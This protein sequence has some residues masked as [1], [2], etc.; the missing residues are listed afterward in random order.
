M[1]FWRLYRECFSDCAVG[2]L[3]FY[4]AAGH[5]WRA[6][7]AWLGHDPE[8]AEICFERWR[9]LL[10]HGKHTQVLMEL[11]RLVNRVTLNAESMKVLAQVQADFQNHCQHVAY[12]AFEQEQLPLGSGLV[13]SACKWLIQQRF[14]W[15][16]MGWSSTGF[17]H[18]LY[19]RLAWV[20][21]RGRYPFPLSPN[22]N[23]QPLDAPRD[24]TLLVRPVVLGLK[25]NTRNGENFHCHSL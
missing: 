14:K 25:K 10:R 9:H 23:P 20:N 15:V 7:T 22:V 19:L 1:G 2:I 17:E 5:L 6:A 11:T 24:E 12:S 4:H 21:Q 8:A 3:D 18:L 16:G 13:E